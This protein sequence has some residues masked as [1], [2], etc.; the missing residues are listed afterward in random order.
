MIRALLALLLALPLAG[1]LSDD[2][3]ETAETVLTLQSGT[4]S[5][6][7][8]RRGTGP[9]TTYPYA[10]DMMLRMVEQAAGMARNEDGEPVRAI[11]VSELRHEVI[12]KER[13]GKEAE[14]DGYAAPFRTAMLAVVHPVRG[15]PG[16]SRVEIHMLQRGPFHRG[17]VNWTRDMPGWITLVIE[18]WKAQ[19][20]A[21]LAPLP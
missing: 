1:C 5:E 7:R 21:P 13:E 8:E 17:V 3:T 4:I 11:F 14:H 6:L 19:E 18:D 10:P 12:A 9:F 15:R 2:V 16:A 20:A